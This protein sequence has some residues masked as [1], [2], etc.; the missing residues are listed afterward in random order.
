MDFF[1]ALFCAVTL[2]VYVFLS[3]CSNDYSFVVYSEAQWHD[4]S[5]SV[6]LCSQ[7][8]LGLWGLI[9]VFSIF[10]EKCH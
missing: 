9:G 3:Y 7:D 5:N 1:L 8:C 6:I 4:I 2:S 10:V